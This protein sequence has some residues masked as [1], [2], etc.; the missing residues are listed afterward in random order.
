[1]KATIEF[2]EYDELVDA[3]NGW[4]WKNAMWELD[5]QMRKVTK[6]GQH[7]GRDATEAEIEITEH[8]RETLRKLINN[9]GL[10]FE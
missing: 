5:Q 9:D 6:H 2:N 8:W 3:I 7:N 1:M 10:N 4:K